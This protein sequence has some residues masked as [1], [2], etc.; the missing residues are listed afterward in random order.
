M[1]QDFVVPE[2]LTIAGI[3]IELANIANENNSPNFLYFDKSITFAISVGRFERGIFRQDICF[4]NRDSETVAGMRLGG[5]SQ[6]TACSTEDYFSQNFLLEDRTPNY[7]GFSLQML[8]LAGPSPLP[9]PG[10]NI[11]DDGVR[12]N[13]RT[14]EDIAHIAEVIRG[15]VSRAH[16]TMIISGSQLVLHHFLTQFPELAKALYPTVE[17]PTRGIRPSEKVNCFPPHSADIGFKTNLVGAMKRLSP[18]DVKA[19]SGLREDKQ[20]K[21]ATELLGESSQKDGAVPVNFLDLFKAWNAGADVQVKKI[22]DDNLGTRAYTQVWNAIEKLKN[23][24]DTYISEDGS[25]MKGLTSQFALNT[26]FGAVPNEE[27]IA[28]DSWQARWP[29]GEYVQGHMLG[30]L[31]GARSMLTTSGPTSPYLPAQKKS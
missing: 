21:N 18:E 14:D 5:G 17:T 24:P 30:A 9:D 25:Y 29:H 19:I 10:P 16:L 15:T 3:G 23:N 12:Y 1:T 26:L 22:E 20:W 28:E 31:L 11:K 8:N 6:S 27:P 13:A 4:V 2:D 7:A